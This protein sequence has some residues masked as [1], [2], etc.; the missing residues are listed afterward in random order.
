MN[1][2]EPQPEQQPPAAEQP[3]DTPPPRIWVGSLADYNAGSLHGQWLDAAQDS[4]L[5]RQQVQAMLSRSRTPGAEEY[6]IFDYDGFGGLRLDEYES[7]DVVARIANGIV[8]HGP[9]FAAWTELVDRDAEQLEQFETAYLGAFENR[10][11]FAQQVIDD[12]GV[13]AALSQSLPTSLASYVSIDVVAIAQDLELSGDI[14][15]ADRDGGG[16]WAFDGRL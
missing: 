4:E 16:V 9:A 6:G 7:L 14:R 13:E 3:A 10:A 1:E 8:E 2:P 12:L 11:A 15:F 5:L